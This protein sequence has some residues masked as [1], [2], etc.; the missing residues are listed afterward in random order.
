MKNFESES[1]FCN[2]NF[3]VYIKIKCCKHNISCQA[4]LDQ[5]APC[6]GITPEF[7]F[8]YRGAHMLIEMRVL[9]PSDVDRDVCTYSL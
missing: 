8:I 6:F 2:F 5:A 3:V 7:W 4:P 9:I 1:N